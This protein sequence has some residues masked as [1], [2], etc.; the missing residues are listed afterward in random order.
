MDE[1]DSSNPW[2][3]SSLTL[4]GSR[5]HGN[6]NGN[7]T[8]ASLNG[9][10][11]EAGGS[12]TGTLSRASARK[13]PLATPSPRSA[14]APGSP[15]ESDD[16]KGDDAEPQ[17]LTPENSVVVH[18]VT[19]ND[20]L[21]SIALRYGADVN[22]ILRAN[23]LWPGDAP[24]MRAEIFI[25]LINCKRTPPDTIVRAKTDIVPAQSGSASGSKSASGLASKS[26]VLSS[27][28]GPG[29]ESLPSATASTA[30]SGGMIVPLAPGFTRP[31]AHSSQHKAASSNAGSNSTNR[32]DRTSREG[33]RDWRPNKWTLGSASNSSNTT[34]SRSSVSMSGSASDAGV[35]SDSSKPPRTDS[36]SK[37]GRTGEGSERG[38]PSRANSD[39]ERASTGWNDA[40]APNARI[41]RAYQGGT[42]RLGHHRL[43]QDLAAGLPPNTGAAA[44]WQRPINDSL[45]ISPGAGSGR[46]GVGAGSAFAGGG[47]VRMGLG[48]DGMGGRMPGIGGM[49]GGSNRAPLG[50]GKILSDTF[51]GRMSVEDAFEAAIQSVSSSVALPAPEM[52]PGRP[53]MRGPD[54]RSLAPGFASP[55]NS[56]QLGSASR[57]QEDGLRVRPGRGTQGSEYET[58]SP[59]GSMR[60]Q[61]PNG[62]RSGQPSPPGHELDRLTFDE[63]SDRTDKK[64]RGLSPPAP[65]QGRVVARQPSRDRL[66]PSSADAGAT[67]SSSM[68]T[69][70]GA[71]GGSGLRARGS[72]RNLDWSAGGQTQ[73]SG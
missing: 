29:A 63:S 28:E 26:S 73:G 51:R 56:P 30:T 42:R 50:F 57:N 58:V 49:P 9:A 47:G 32:T 55:S 3:Q 17:K 18:P 12:S 31:T 27:R 4:Q 62:H 59:F 7:G 44:N 54:G 10:S 23:R 66:H 21:S 2:G 35:I 37:G 72:L 40:P 22:T 33:E 64:Q 45:P 69:T 8:H 53:P 13:H 20:S 52:P 19:P 38:H 15:G 39:V 25:P 14:H 11:P 60:G 6:G 43:L 71:T 1:S 70:T 24:Q 67:S 48:A 5:R 41:A 61:T 46:P 65:Q 16:P 68:T 36:P 34:G